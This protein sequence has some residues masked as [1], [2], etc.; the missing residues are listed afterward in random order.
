MYGASVL[1]MF[2]YLVCGKLG[3]VEV[4][5]FGQMF[6][7]VVERLHITGHVVKKFVLVVFLKWQDFIVYL[8][9]GYPWQ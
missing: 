4:R 5:Y 8:M 9:C 6:F 3:I 7:C 1:L 2:S